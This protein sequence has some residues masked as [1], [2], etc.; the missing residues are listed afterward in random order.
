MVK[1]IDYTRRL[2]GMGKGR[3][4]PAPV[5]D[6]IA[7]GL[8]VTST[9]ATAWF[10]IAPSNTDLLSDFD[11]N[12]EV[13]AVVKNLGQKLAGKR[14]HLR[15]VWS[16]TTGEQYEEAI[17]GRYSAGDWRRW[18]R[19]RADAI[20]ALDLPERHVF[21][22]VV[23]DVRAKHADSGLE[24]GV[25]SA[26]GLRD[27]RVGEKEMTEHLRKA[28]VLGKQ[29]QQSKLH[30]RT[31]TAE[32]LSWLL[33][34]AQFRRGGAVPKQGVIEGAALAQLTR[35]RVVPYP[36]HLRMF[37]G[38]GEVVAYQA[39]LPVTDFPGEVEVT[40]ARSQYLRAL[41]D[42][43]RPT[44]DGEEVPVI[45]EASVRFDVLGKKAARKMITSAHELAKEQRRSA[46][47]GMAGDPGSAI[48]ETEVITDALLQEMRGDGVSI[49]RSHPRLIVTESSYDDL[50]GAIDAVVGYY[51]DAG[52][53]VS[54]GEDEQRD[55]FLETLPGDRVRIDDLGHIQDGPGFFGSL[56]WG[57][58]TLPQPGFAIG[59]VT[60]S[61]PSP[62][63]FDLVRFAED[64]Q[65]T[66]VGIFGRSGK[67]KS[68]LLE[69]LCLDAAF[70][71]AW[72]QLID[73]KGDLG[74]VVTL[75][76]EY[77]LP[78]HLLSL[79]GTQPSGSLDLFRALNLD[80]AQAEVANQLLL[81]SPQALRLHA[82]EVLLEF[83]QTMAREAQV[84]GVEPSAHRVIELLR[85]DASDATRRLGNALLA[86]SRTPIGRLLIGPVER[87]VE[88]VLTMTPGLWNIQLPPTGNPPMN[89]PVSEWD[90]V[91]RLGVAL[92]RTI[93]THSV[94]VT[95]D[96]SMT[97]MKK[98]V[99]MPEVHRI[100]A[101][102]DGGDFLD[103]TAR[104]GR[105][106]NAHLVI[107]SQD[108]T[109]VA[110]NEGLVEQLVAVFGFQL[111]TSRQQDA[112]AEMLHLA[113]DDAATEDARALI[114]ALSLSSTAQTDIKGD[115]L[116]WVADAGTGATRIQVEL[117]N[118]RVMDLLDTTP[119]LGEDEPED[120]NADP[121]ALTAEDVMLTEEEVMQ[122]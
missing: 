40:D 81:L 32:S 25:R 59:Q 86:T 44:D 8:I 73:P 96:R 110:A 27:R 120:P 66:T 58:S 84:A 116:A 33:G 97:G 79:D 38:Q 55:L 104:M 93:L 60:G 53:D 114:G 89:Q 48:E 103:T 52:M 106:N 14:C 39:V 100:L 91:Q 26:F 95:G 94:S 67:G 98:V 64:R 6:A 113:V 108:V 57:G 65:S 119:G 46:G 107:D 51:S 111:Q 87:G 92:Q 69:L 85:E 37:D 122:P 78:T 5:Y 121:D 16:T 71:G 99:A 117:P 13:D 68:T 45:V 7:D 76:R 88:S 75:A 20:D 1:A 80:K 62:F 12:R 4:A 105:A 61:T 29:L 74:G 50:R 9:E 54:E 70:S 11:I 35:G 72:V 2:L 18:A 77:G 24:N 63:L 115:A 90:P 23:I 15:V 41:S 36:D 34:R 10:E 82:D 49:I 101:M 28:R 17:A 112:L 102:R 43:T 30:V 22:G 109:G 56:F 83:T 42:I 3:D 31:A 118:T 21:L 19:D 47:Q